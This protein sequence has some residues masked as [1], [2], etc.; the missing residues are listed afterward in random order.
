[1]LEYELVAGNWDDTYEEHVYNRCVS[2][3]EELPDMYTYMSNQTCIDR[4]LCKC[5][6]IGVIYYASTKDFLESLNLSIESVLML[7]SSY[8][9]Y[10]LVK[11]N[12][13]QRD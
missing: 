11:H 7:K 13:E 3:S 8:N 6:V 9:S 1:M 5:F 2:T 4:Y 10:I 12:L